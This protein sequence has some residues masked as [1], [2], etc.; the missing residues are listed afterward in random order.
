MYVYLVS[1][2]LVCYEWLQIL[3]NCYQHVFW[4]RLLDSMV[5]YYKFSY[6]T[7]LSSAYPPHPFGYVWYS[8]QHVYIF[9]SD[10]YFWMHA[11][12]IYHNHHLHVG[13]IIVLVNPTKIQ[14]MPTCIVL[15]GWKILCGMDAFKS[16]YRCEVEDLNFA[17]GATPFY[18]YLLNLFI[19]HPAARNGKVIPGQSRRHRSQV[20]LPVHIILRSH[21]QV[22]WRE[23]EVSCSTLHYIVIFAYAPVLYFLKQ[24]VK[25]ILWYMGIATEDYLL[26]GGGGG[27][28]QYC[29]KKKKPHYQ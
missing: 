21:V 19:H 12:C 17:T 26:L 8:Q 6:K 16:N 14:H 10:L 23:W 28:L 29:K 4:D 7:F 3:I 15:R 1:H 11:C 9:T 24:S 27:G 22:A 25:L 20:H 13:L 2:V 5:V 18:S